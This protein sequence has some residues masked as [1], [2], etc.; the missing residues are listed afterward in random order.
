MS[1]KSAPASRQKKSSK[2]KDAWLSRRRALFF[3]ST[4]FIHLVLSPFFFFFIFEL[5]IYSYLHT[6]TPGHGLTG[7]DTLNIFNPTV[8]AVI[9]AICL[10]LVGLMVLVVFVTVRRW[11]LLDRARTPKIVSSSQLT[12]GSYK[13]TQ[14]IEDDHN[15]VALKAGDLFY[16]QRPWSAFFSANH[17]YSILL[18]FISWRTTEIS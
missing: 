5:F 18:C 14:S 7:S 8:A 12:P 2:R 17:L 10:V 11:R 15:V 6:R 1:K 3:R 4:A 9:G 13:P 16:P